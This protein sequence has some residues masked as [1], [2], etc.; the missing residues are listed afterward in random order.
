MFHC[1]FVSWT[2]LTF[3]R[4]LY[5]F[6]YIPSKDSLL[7]IVLLSIYMYFSN[8]RHCFSDAWRYRC[9][10]RPIRRPAF[11]PEKEHFV[12]HPFNLEQ[13]QWCRRKRA[14]INVPRE[15]AGATRKCSEVNFLK[16]NIIFPLDIIKRVKLTLDLPSVCC[17]PLRLIVSCFIQCIFSFSFNTF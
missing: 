13:R 9:L 16:N 8:V 2:P 10:W 14:H 6:E 1:L 15:G 7:T 3:F 17:I 5:Y 4:F 11:A 12:F